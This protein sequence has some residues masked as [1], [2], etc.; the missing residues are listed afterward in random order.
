MNDIEID[1]NYFDLN[2]INIINN[3][4]IERLQS[5]MNYMLENY[6]VDND[7]SDINAIQNIISSLFGNEFDANHFYRQMKYLINKGCYNRLVKKFKN[8]LIN[9][10]F[11]E[12]RVE[13]IVEMIKSHYEK[14]VEMQK[15][16]ELNL[17]RSV[18]NFEI[19]T[20]M[21]VM[22]TN[23]KI[24]NAN[25]EANRDM[26]KQNI[27]MKFKFDNNK[28]ESNLNDEI[29]IQMDKTQLVDFYGEI[30][31]IQEKLDLLY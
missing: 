9:L 14:I 17:N 25:G 29:I 21:P 22:N 18:V 10:N 30:E 11:Q 13:L 28:G 24:S 8:D 20:E 23:Y 1:K 27:L 4:E 2:F 16:N 31:K 12:S 6:S 3:C 19:K 5:F 15:Q 7:A 26:K